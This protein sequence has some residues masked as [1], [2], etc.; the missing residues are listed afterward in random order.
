MLQAALEATMG[1]F[2]DSMW[3]RKVLELA[4]GSAAAGCS[5]AG[6]LE[7]IRSVPVACK[8]GRLLQRHA[9]VALLKRAIPSQACP[10][11]EWQPRSSALSPQHSTCRPGAVALCSDGASGSSVTKNAH[12]A[13][14]RPR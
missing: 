7:A 4:A 6:G 5:P 13:C 9:L 10:E 3:E 12:G 8:R 1:A 2:Q 14:P 11:P